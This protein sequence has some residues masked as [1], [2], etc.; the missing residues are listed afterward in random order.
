MIY[1][2]S[3]HFM[4]MYFNRYSF[5]KPDGLLSGVIHEGVFPL[6]AGPLLVHF[7][8]VARGHKANCVGMSRMSDG[9][10]HDSILSEVI[11]SVV[12]NVVDF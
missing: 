9:N 8:V 5:D 7:M 3:L 12:E 1:L 2:S 4:F 10:G 6:M 11:L